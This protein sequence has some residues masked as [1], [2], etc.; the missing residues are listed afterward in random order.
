M[1]ANG[2]QHIFYRGLDA[3]INHIWWDG[4]PHKDQWTESAVAEKAA[5]NPAAM[6]TR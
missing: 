5:G 1:M 2:Q 3:A 4:S 6:V